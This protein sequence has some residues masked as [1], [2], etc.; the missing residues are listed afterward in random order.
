MRNAKNG[1][2][3][4]PEPPIR[5]MRESQGSSVSVRIYRLYPRE[6]RLHS[7]HVLTRACRHRVDRQMRSPLGSKVASRAINFTRDPRPAAF[8]CPIARNVELEMLSTRA[9]DLLQY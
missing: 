9:G 1:C 6:A 7:A 4:S 2:V 8:A 3:P 5:V